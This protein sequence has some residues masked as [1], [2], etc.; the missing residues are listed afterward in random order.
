MIRWVD[1]VSFNGL[2]TP[3]LLAAMRLEELYRT[4]ANA[5]LWIT[6]GNDRK[7]MDGSK[8]YSGKAL[9]FRTKMLTAEQRRMIRDSAVKALGPEFTVLLEDEGG[10]NE[11]LHVQ[12]NK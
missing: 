8:H 9:D 4:H 12:Y 7:H 5:D 2:G 6:S 1:S 10:A 3:M 11:H